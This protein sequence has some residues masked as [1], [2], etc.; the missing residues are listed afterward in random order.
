MYD[1]WDSDG[2]RKR[3]YS[4]GINIT[5]CNLH[6]NR[7]N[8]LSI[9]DA[10]NVTIENCEFNYASGTSPEYGID[11]EPNNGYTCSNITISHSRFQG[12]AGGTIQILGQS[13]AHVK[14]V[15]LE[16]CTGDKAP[17]IW[18][19]FGGSVRGVTQKNNKWN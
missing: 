17:V 7:R 16:N 6:H 8:N 13:N 11:I 9:T 4:S 2:N 18:Q 3:F 1:G 15:T 5:N 10:S 14:D 19:G 12:N